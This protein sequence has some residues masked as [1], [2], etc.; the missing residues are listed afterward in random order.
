MKLCKIAFLT[1]ISAIILLFSGCDVNNSNTLSEA[2][3]STPITQISTST[4]NVSEISLESKL[5]EIVEEHGLSSLNTTFNWQKYVGVFNSTEHRGLVSAIFGDFRKTGKEDLITAVL[6]EKDG[7]DFLDVDLYFADEKGETAKTSLLSQNVDYVRGEQPPAI[8]IKNFNNSAYFC[9]VGEGGSMY[10]GGSVYGTYLLVTEILPTGEAAEQVV[11]SSGHGAGTDFS[12]H[13]RKG[14]RTLYDMYPGSPYDSDIELIASWNNA[15]SA[16]N[17]ELIK[18]GLEDQVYF[19]SEYSSNPDIKA[20]V[21]VFCGDK[22]DITKIL[23]G[24]MDYIETDY[25]EPKPQ[26]SLHGV[27]YTD[28]TGVREYLKYKPAEVSMS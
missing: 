16:V 17:G 18:Y 21:F 3:G 14:N 15:Y 13:I 10:Y 26:G 12:V 7:S 20:F 6:S 5:M 27:Y 9:M 22:N 4:P 23:S 25:I 8:F 2:E 28:Y 19:I 1:V 11:F 24:K